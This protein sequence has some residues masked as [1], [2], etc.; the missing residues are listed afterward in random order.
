MV[1]AREMPLSSEIQQRFSDHP[2]SLIHASLWSWWFSWLE[3]NWEL[4]VRLPIRFRD[5]IR[6]IIHCPANWIP[7]WIHRENAYQ[8]HSQNSAVFSQIPSDPRQN[9]NRVR[10]TRQFWFRLGLELEIGPW[11]RFWNGPDFLLRFGLTLRLSPDFPFGLDL[12]FGSELNK[13]WRRRYKVEL[14]PFIFLDD[15]ALHCHCLIYSWRTARSWVY[16]RPSET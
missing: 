14:H 7:K 1:R 16:T 9:I 6:E 11:L 8:N 15:D 2:R 13:F 5:G 3:R 12:G 4:T 10:I